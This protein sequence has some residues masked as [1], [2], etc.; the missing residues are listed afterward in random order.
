MPSQHED[1][2]LIDDLLVGERA[3]VLLQVAGGPQQTEH[4]VRGPLVTLSRRA[5][6]MSVTSWRS[7]RSPSLSLR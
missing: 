6:M 1:Q 7:T 3:G 2:H 4:V 5:A